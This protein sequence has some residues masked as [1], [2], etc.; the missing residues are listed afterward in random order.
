[1]PKFS[2]LLQLIE[3]AIQYF[4]E[5]R[6]TVQ[7]NCS[8]FTACYVGEK[9]S[10]Y[11]GEII[12]ID[13]ANL[14]SIITREYPRIRKILHN[15]RVFYNVGTPGEY[16]QLCSHWQDKKYSCNCNCNTADSRH[17]NYSAPLRALIVAYSKVWRASQIFQV[18]IFCFLGALVY[19]MQ[20]SR[21]I[22]RIRN[23]ILT[24]V[25]M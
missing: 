12:L 22:I 25:K 21:D 16:G 5:Q 6:A 8:N 11:V 19:L 9:D 3:T 20:C 13:V 24:A 15:Q 10:T 17:S 4:R 14:L 7:L 1:M 18:K 23:N 2:I